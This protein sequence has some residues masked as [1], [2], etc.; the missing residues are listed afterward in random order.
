MMASSL[1][2][3]V[4]WLVVA[5]QHV[6]VSSAT[7]MARTDIETW[8]LAR[9]DGTR[10][11]TN[12]KAGGPKSSNG[13][14]DDPLLIRTCSNRSVFFN[15][16]DPGFDDDDIGFTFDDVKLFA[17]TGLTMQV[18]TISAAGMFIGDT[19]QSMGEGTFSFFDQDGLVSFAIHS[20]GVTFPI[21]G[22]T[23]EF[24]CASGFVRFVGGENEEQEGYILTVC[25]PFCT[26]P[27]DTV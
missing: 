1:A 10:K 26:A 20:D 13:E 21:T 16:G 4:S 27:E 3:I 24:L 15:S 5:V 22:G 25:G 23:G 9:N 7:A 18:G 17:D 6:G 8:S 14:S 2:A 19:G 11:L 12:S